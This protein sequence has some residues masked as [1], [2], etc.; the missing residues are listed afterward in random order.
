MNVFDIPMIENDADALTIGEYF[1]ML[2]IMVWRDKEGFSGKRPFGNSGW[3]H[4]VY[5]SLVKAGVVEG[6][7]DDDWYIIDCNYNKA[8][9]LIYNAILDM[10]KQ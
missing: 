10:F 6:K 3:D 8:D 9:K 5:A 4:E 1:Y 7:F 2:L